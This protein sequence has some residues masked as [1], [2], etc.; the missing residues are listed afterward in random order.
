[1]FLLISVPS[2]IFFSKKKKFLKKTEKEGKYCIISFS[3]CIIYMQHA[4]EGLKLDSF[5]GLQ[6]GQ[7]VDSHAPAPVPL[8]GVNT[9][10]SITDVSSFPTQTL[11]P[12]PV[13]VAP[14][15]TDQ[16]KN[17]I[18]SISPKEVTPVAK[19]ALEAVETA[20]S[21][22][23]VLE[24]DVNLVTSTTITTEKLATEKIFSCL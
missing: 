14:V 9:P 10:S 12:S 13:H 1:M 22:V 8:S 15:I 21:V 6:A 11:A 4:R 16:P 3:C 23:T 2:S 7:D 24:K 19:D 20:A 17:S 5:I 18:S